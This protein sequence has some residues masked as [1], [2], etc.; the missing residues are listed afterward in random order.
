MRWDIIISSNRQSCD[1]RTTK[2]GQTRI[3]SLFTKEKGGSNGMGSAAMPMIRYNGN[4]TVHLTRAHSRLHTTELLRNG[5]NPQS[6]GMSLGP[7]KAKSDTEQKGYG[8]CYS[9]SFNESSSAARS[10][11]MHGCP[12]RWLEF[13]VTGP[14]I[15]FRRPV[16]T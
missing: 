13:L 3:R 14:T 5:C 2:R 8:S 11:N 6:R 9:H 12:E 1:T 10:L 7:Q 4:T 15:G 16:T